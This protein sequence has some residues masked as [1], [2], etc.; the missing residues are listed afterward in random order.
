[1]SKEIFSEFFSIGSAR[2]KKIGRLWEVGVV[3]GDQ[4]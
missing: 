2:K 3:N 1:M 4:C